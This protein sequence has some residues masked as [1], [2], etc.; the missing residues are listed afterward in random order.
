MITNWIEL[1]LARKIPVTI[2]RFTPD[3]RSPIARVL[4]RFSACVMSFQA[5]TRCQFMIKRFAEWR[6]GKNLHCV[7]V[8]R[9][10]K[11]PSMSGV[12]FECGHPSCSLKIHQKPM[13]RQ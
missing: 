8:D 3:R 9:Q 5:S 13:N 12:A 11:A 2:D 1:K 4:S 7:W 10:L 6:R